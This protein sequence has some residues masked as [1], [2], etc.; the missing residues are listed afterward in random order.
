MTLTLF[1]IN[2]TNFGP[3]PANPEDPGQYPVQVAL[4]LLPSEWS[5]VAASLAGVAPPASLINWIPIPYEATIYPM[6]AS[7]N[8]GIAK[9]KAAILGCPVGTPKAVASYSQGSLPWSTVWRD[10]IL[11]PAGD[12]H[13]YLDDF[14]ACVN[15][16]NPM[17]CPTIPANGNTYAGW[18]QQTGGGISGTNDLTAAQT[19]SWWLDFADPNDLYTDSPVGTAAGTDEELIYNCIVSTSFGGTLA[20]LLVVL[21]Q[22]VKQ[23]SNPWKEIV[24]IATAIYNGLRFLAAGPGAGHYT[25]RIGPAISYMQSVAL[26]YA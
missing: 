6:G 3:G 4:A 11:N 12:L 25:Y 10:H 14:V 5:G 18:A 8:D 9:L 13:A 24:G 23:F 19:P 17:R 1:T 7:V 2:G 21:E 20:G 26:Q 22:L 15:W 16:G